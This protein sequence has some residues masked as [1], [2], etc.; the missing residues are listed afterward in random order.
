MRTSCRGLV[1][2][3]CLGLLSGLTACG[4][5]EDG[6]DEPTSMTEALAVRD[7]SIAPAVVVSADDYYGGRW[8]EVRNYSTIYFALINRY[9][10]GSVVESKW[11]SPRT[12]DHIGR[13]SVYYDATV[14]AFTCSSG[15]C[16]PVRGSKYKVSALNNPN[17]WLPN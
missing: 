3:C 13:Y 14:E 11:V 5:A 7:Q 9:D 16:Y 1:I 17:G 4:S 8:L 2:G 15:F 6:A 10:R 12:Y